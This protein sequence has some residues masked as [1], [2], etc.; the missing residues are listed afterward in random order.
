M[1]QHPDFLIIPGMLLGTPTTST[2]Q[3]GYGIQTSPAMGEACAALAR[4]ETVPARLLGFGLAPSMLGPARLVHGRLSF[5]Q[6]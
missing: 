5:R 1:S 3:G 4:G 6:S 2:A